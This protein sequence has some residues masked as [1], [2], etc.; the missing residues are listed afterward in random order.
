[1][2]SQSELNISSRKQNRDQKGVKREILPASD[3]KQIAPK[4]ESAVCM[5]FLFPF[6]YSSSVYKVTIFFGTTFQEMDVQVSVQSTL[7]N[8]N[9]SFVKE[10]SCLL[11]RPLSIQPYPN[12]W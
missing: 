4:R 3:T 12:Y 1:M 2:K 11:N 9:C 6:T 8:S 10:L 7:G 5:V